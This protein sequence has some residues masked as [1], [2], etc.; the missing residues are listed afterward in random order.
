M[1]TI[2]QLIELCICLEIMLNNAYSLDEIEEDIKR[3]AKILDTS[4]IN[5]SIIFSAG[6]EM[7]ETALPQ[8]TTKKRISFK[9]APIPSETTKP[10]ESVRDE[11][12]S[13][14]YDRDRTKKRPSSIKVSTSIDSDIPEAKKTKSP[15][16][17]SPMSKSPKKTG[18]AKDKEA[19]TTKASK[20]ASSVD[21]KFPGIDVKFVGGQRIVKNTPK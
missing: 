13:D 20:D 4:P 1:K 3:G 7:P 11:D 9:K 16:D 14:A 10:D 21:A 8:E 18:S 2:F 5:Q 19:K 15:K 12:S 17:K 6:E